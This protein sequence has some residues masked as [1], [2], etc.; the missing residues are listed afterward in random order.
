MKVLIVYDTSTGNTEKMA[1]AVED[2]VTKAGVEVIFKHVDEASVDEIPQCQGLILG[3][4]VYYGLPSGKIKKFIDDS[5]KY[6]G[7]LDG[8]VGGAF[9]SAGGTHT[10]AETTIIAINEMLFVHG[11]I[12]QG[13]SAG[14][15]YGAA[16]VGSP[17]DASLEACRKL[18][19]RVGKLVKRLN[20]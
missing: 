15:H 19:E 12:I 10:G 6:H 13:S 11:M 2:G 3:S 14:S 18:G 1:H 8:T 9:A 4:P 17:N 5:I 20:K 16:S 7:K